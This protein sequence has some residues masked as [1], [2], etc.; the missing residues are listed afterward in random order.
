MESLQISCDSLFN[1]CDVVAVLETNTV[2]GK[3]DV[4][5]QQQ[6]GDRFEES[7]RR[8]GALIPY[9]RWEK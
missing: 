3:L 8:S 4:F 6:D 9:S 7:C 1:L 2:L 5:V